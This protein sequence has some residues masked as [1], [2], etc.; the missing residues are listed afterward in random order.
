[1]MLIHLEICALIDYSEEL[2]VTRILSV[3]QTG[4][5]KDLMTVPIE[6]VLIDDELI[7][8]SFIPG[9]AGDGI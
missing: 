9:S 8:K 5:V 2:V 4:L 3:I 7:N 6:C 1:M